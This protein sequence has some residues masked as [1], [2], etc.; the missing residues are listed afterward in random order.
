[1]ESR[2]LGSTESARFRA[3]RRSGATSAAPAAGRADA[4][5]RASAQRFTRS[6]RSRASRA[7]HPAG[8]GCAEPYPR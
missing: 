5:I 2:A 3:S 7:H 4:R 8:H 6:S 1:M